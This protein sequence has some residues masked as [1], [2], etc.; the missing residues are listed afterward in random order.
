MS[1]SGRRSTPSRA[2][3]SGKREGGAKAAA[4]VGYHDAS[5]VAR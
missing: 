4:T 5:N 2:T 1:K 3:P